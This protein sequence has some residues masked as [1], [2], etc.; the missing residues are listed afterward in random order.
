MRNYVD[1]GNGTIATDRD[2]DGVYDDILNVTR[3]ANGVIHFDDDGDGVFDD[4]IY[5]VSI[6]DINDENSHQGTYQSRNEENIYTSSRSTGS[7]LS[8]K[9]KWIIVA[10]VC[11]VFF[12]SSFTIP[13][14]IFFLSLFV[15]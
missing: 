2:G 15:R 4:S 1:L 5:A 13:V 11:G 14:I 7:I 6:N 10:V 9:A 8:R 12:V 3:D